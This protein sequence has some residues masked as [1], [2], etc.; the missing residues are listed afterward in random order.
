MD[1][2][3]ASNLPVEPA[4]SLGA[5]EIVALDVDDLRTAQAATPGLAAFLAQVVLTA[6]QR[7]K[8]MEL[9]LAAARRIPVHHISLL[10]EHPTALWDF[11]QTPEAIE[12]GYQL[13]RTAIR[14]LNLAGRARWP[15]WLRWLR[16][17]TA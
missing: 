1:G 7:E 12:R 8:Q 6:Q 15:K 10:L 16:P 4:L 14:R 5:T 3:L 11:R 2:G 17:A 13:T 9:A